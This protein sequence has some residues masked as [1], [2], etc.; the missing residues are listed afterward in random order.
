MQ[1]IQT[2]PQNEHFSTLE[3]TALCFSRSL[4]YFRSG[5]EPA[6]RKNALSIVVLVDSQVAIQALIKCTV[7][8]LTAFNYIKNLN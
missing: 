4:S 6:L 2:T 3:Y 5:K 7:T 8:S 1:N